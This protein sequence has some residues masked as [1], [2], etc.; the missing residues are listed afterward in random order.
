[1]KNKKFIEVLAECKVKISEYVG[2]T[3]KLNSIDVDLCN[4][5]IVLSYENDD[6]RVSCEISQS[7]EE[8]VISGWDIIEFD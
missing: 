4:G 1:M 8:Y 7:G 2:K 6:M 3:I 5:Y